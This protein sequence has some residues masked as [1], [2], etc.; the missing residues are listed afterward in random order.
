MSGDFVTWALQALLVIGIGRVWI[1]ID[2]N[3]ESLANLREELPKT[4]VDKLQFEKLETYSHD[5]VHDLKQKMHA[6]E[7]DA[8]RRGEV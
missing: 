4:Y 3:T 1:A 5:N 7:L 6:L 8:A 2:R